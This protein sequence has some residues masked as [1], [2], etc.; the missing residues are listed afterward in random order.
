MPEIND[1]INPA[2]WTAEEIY[3]EAQMDHCYYLFPTTLAKFKMPPRLILGVDP[4]PNIFTRV[5]R[6]GFRIESNWLQ[7]DPTM[8]LTPDELQ[9]VQFG[10]RCQVCERGDNWRRHRGAVTAIECMLEVYCP[11][12]RF[13]RAELRRV[14]RLRILT[15]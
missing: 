14:S 15:Q 7:L 9:R 13:N 12:R 11:C 4:D 1:Q 2:P 5:L 6:Y 3:L 8:D 10:G